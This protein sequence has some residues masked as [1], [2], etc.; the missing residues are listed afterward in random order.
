M[1]AYECMGNLSAATTH[2]H[3][4]T[5]RMGQHYDSLKLRLAEVSDLRRASAVLG[6]DQE[7]YM[8]EK[9]VDE[10][11]EQLSTLSCLAHQA[12]TSA[13][14]GKL[15]REAAKEEDAQKNRVKSAVVRVAQYDYTQN[16]KVPAEFVAQISKGAI[17]GHNR[18]GQSAQRKQLPRLC[19]VSQEK[20]RERPPPGRLFGLEGSPV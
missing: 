4:Q 3:L 13:A 18:V 20:C 12:F 19:A 15:L 10:R 5:S 11:S 14:T 2:F 9:G 16:K 6:W 7:T 8:P 17:S 1:P